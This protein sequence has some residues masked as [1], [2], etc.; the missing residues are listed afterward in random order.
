MDKFTCIG[1]SHGAPAIPADKEQWTAVRRD[2]K[3]AEL[4]RKIAECKDEETCRKLKSQLPVWTPRCA[5][6]R[7]NHRAEKDALRP[8]NRLMLDIDEKGLTDSIMQKIAYDS[9]NHAWLCR[10]RVLMVEESVR[11]GTHIMLEIRD[12]DDPTRLQDEVSKALGVKV[13]PAVKNRAGCIYMVPDGYTRFVDERL[14][15]MSPLQGSGIGDNKNDS[16]YAPSTPLPTGEGQGGASLPTGEGQ[17]GSYH[18]IPYSDIVAKY[19]ELFNDGK[20]PTAGDRNVKTFEL[21]MAVRSICDYDQGLMEKVIP[22]YWQAPS[23]PS[24]PPQPSPEGEGV[25]EWRKTIENALKEPRKSMPYRLRQVLNA[26]RKSAQIEATGGTASCPPERPKKLPPLL[27]LLTSKVPEVYKTAVCESV[28]PA[29]G[30]HLHQVEFRY[31]NNE[32]VGPNFM[33]VLAAPMSVGKGCVNPPI[34]HIMADIRKRDEESRRRDREWRDNN[35]RK[36]ANKEKTPR[37]TDLCIQWLSSDL[38]NAALVQRMADAERNGERY[39]YIRMDEIELLNQLRTTGKADAVTQLIKLAFNN[40]VYGQER[41]GTDSVNETAHVRWNW[42]ASTTPANLRRFL[43]GGANDGTLSRLNLTTILK[44][45]DSKMPVYGLYDEKFDEQL[46]PFIERLNG[47]CGL[48]ECSEV[49][50]L[51]KTLIAENDERAARVE[52]DAYRVLS[53]RANVIAFQKAMLLYI[54]HGYRWTKE[55]EDYIRWSEQMD[56][57]CKMR[58][59]GDVLELEMQEEAN[60][61]NHD[62]RDLLAM[63][64]EQ[65]SDE[66]FLELRQRL[67]KKGDG[68]ST[69]RT[70]K[71]RKLVDMDDVTGMWINIKK[72]RA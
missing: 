9:E 47:C 39:L 64:P 59:F 65:F 53:Y 22:N 15:T 69:L 37:P 56:L 21:A 1:R 20:V 31:V 36:G 43:R 19:W 67:G 14:F 63:L 42:N 26:L 61:A 40:A 24:A 38:T 49:N 30:A 44:P 68:R 13:D 33:T 58:Y 11:K 4:C 71:T 66:E 3:L 27:A 10:R 35:K 25:G 45:E 23:Q 17:G 54:A 7:N 5:E 6:F 28:W 29:L 48:I 57:W 72:V 50:A 18:G 16:A 46:K 8:L 60:M 34:D 32:T 2:P 41:V 70:W 55:M 52:S 51:A 62:P 12:D